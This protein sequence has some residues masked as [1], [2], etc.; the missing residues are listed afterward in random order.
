MDRRKPA[1]SRRSA[2]FLE[3]DVL[4]RAAAA[5]PA[6]FERKRAAWAG[7]GPGCA[8]RSAG[9]VSDGGSELLPAGRHSVQD[10]PD[11]HGAFLGSAS[12]V[13]GSPDCG[14]RG[15]AAGWF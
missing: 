14:V 5:D 12:A 4:W 11:E 2:L 8:E 3:R 13:F 6:G 1:A 7:T 9:A 10:R 15:G